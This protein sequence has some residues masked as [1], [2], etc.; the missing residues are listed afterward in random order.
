MTN[1]IVQF[2]Q[3][4][5]GLSFKKK[6]Q[7][8]QMIVVSGNKIRKHTKTVIL[9]I[10]SRF[11]QTDFTSVDYAIALEK[12]YKLE[13]LKEDVVRTRATELLHQVYQNLIATKQPTRLIRTISLPSVEELSPAFFEFKTMEDATSSKDKM[14]QT[15]MV[16]FSMNQPWGQQVFAVLQQVTLAPQRLKIEI[17]NGRFE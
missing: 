7:G 5:H 15:T 17:P 4:M 16:E 2:F 14:R 9:E 13:H 3:D 11:V 6:E 1:K 10:N 8:K 12:A